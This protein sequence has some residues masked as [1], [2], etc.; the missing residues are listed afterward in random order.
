MDARELVEKAIDAGQYIIATA[1]IQNGRLIVSHT[2]RDFPRADIPLA[3]LHLAAQLAKVAFP[4]SVPIGDAV[5][6]VPEQAEP[7]NS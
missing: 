3:H 4:A 6:F 2:S 5:A 7:G 1:V